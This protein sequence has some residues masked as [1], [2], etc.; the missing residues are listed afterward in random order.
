MLVLIFL[1]YRIC[2]SREGPHPPPPEISSTMPEPAGNVV[3]VAEETGNFKTLLNILSELEVPSLRSMT[4]VDIL[5]MQREVTVFA[6]TDEAFAKLPEGTLESLTKEQK[7]EL[8]SRHFVTGVIVLAADIT[9]GTEVETFGGES[10]NLSNIKGVIG[11]SYKGSYINAVSQDVKA[12]N[13]VIH[14]INEVMLPGNVVDVAKAAGNFKTLLKILS[15]LEVPS[16]KSMTLVD[17]LKMQREVTVFAPTDE[18]FAK[19]PKGTLESLTKEQKLAIVS[20]HFVPGVIILKADVTGRVAN[21][22]TVHDNLLT[23]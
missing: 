23:Q 14:V 18:A 6:P 16:V 1:Y 15:E 7:L 8:V 22:V 3:D 9:I 10:I 2:Q 20:R 17:F 12:S 5:K 11:V 13:G 4:L 21:V 19:L